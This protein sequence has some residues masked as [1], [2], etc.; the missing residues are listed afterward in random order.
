MSCELIANLYV[1]V[2]WYSENE[3]VEAGGGIGVEAAG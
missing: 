3:A 1:A 2:Y